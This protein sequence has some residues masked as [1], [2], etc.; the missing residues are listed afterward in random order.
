MDLKVGLSECGARATW[1]GYGAPRLP[2]GS[3]AGTWSPPCGARPLTEP[4]G[5][6]SLLTTVYFLFLLQGKQE[7]EGNYHFLMPSLD[8]HITFHLCRNSGKEFCLLFFFLMWTIF[9]VFIE[10]LTILLLFY[11]LVFWPQGMWNLNSPTR[12]QT[13]AP[14]VGR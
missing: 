9:T 12:D 11:V 6:S 8:Q 5:E 1:H 3:N 7:N 13:R 14:C 4:P 2:Q 10:F